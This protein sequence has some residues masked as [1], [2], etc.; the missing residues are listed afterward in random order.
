MGK[1]L[2]SKL[3]RDARQLRG[4]ASAIGLVVAAGVAALVSL[5]ST[6]HS[7]SGARDAYLA[8]YRFA[9]VFVRLA[10]T[11]ERIVGEV[12]DIPGV[13]DVQGRLVEDARLAGL[14][15]LATGR[16][17][18]LGG[19]GGAALNDLHLREGR[20]PQ[21]DLPGEAVVSEA[22]AKAHG[23]RPGATVKALV[24][25]RELQLRLSGIVLSPEYVYQIREG[26][27]APDDRRF[28][29]FW[30]PHRQL[31]RALGLEGAVNELSL[32]LVVR[33]DE[34]EVIERLDRLLA[35][36]GGLG[37]I[38]RD[39]QLSYRYLAEELRQL[40]SSGTSI[41]IVFLLV[42]S[43]LLNVVMSRLVKTQRMQIAMLK[44]FGYSNARIAAH[45]LSLALG[46][47]LVGVLVGV[48][49]GAWLGHELT[50]LYTRF[51]RLPDF[52][53]DLDVG[54]S[55]A[56]GG[57]AFLA[58]GL[59]SLG[60]IR[61]ATR[62]MPAEA[63]RPEAPPVYRPTRIERLGL[64]WLVSPAWRMIL[65]RMERRPWR[66]LSST[67][68][69]AAATAILV[70]GLFF[71][72]AIAHVVDFQLGVLQRHDLVLSFTSARS[73][74]ARHEVERLSGVTRAQG[75][76]AVP[77]ELGAG[78]RR[79][80]V[81]VLG[82][83]PADEL[84]R[85]VD[86]EGRWL[87]LPQ[88]GLILSS[89]LARQLELV[90]GDSVEVRVLERNGRRQRLTLAAVVR[91]VAGLSAYMRLDAAQRLMRKGNVY[92]GLFVVTDSTP[93]GEALLAALGRMPHLAAVSEVGTALRG[94][95]ET[96][97]RALLVM[98]LIMAAFAAVIA[99]GVIYNDGRVALAERQH[100]L[101]TLRVLGFTTGEIA[102]LFLGE[103][104]LVVVVALPVGLALGHGLARAIIAS[105][106]KDL[107][108]IPLVIELSTYVSAAL[109]IA[110]A[111]AIMAFP[112]A[113]QLARLDLVATLKARD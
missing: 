11:S 47:S 88:H 33:G 59:G 91:D 53:F 70:V 41:P 75:F 28:G 104:M 40:W 98:K 112:L 94:F 105:T 17:Q 96:F 87:A 86:I 54:V 99:V 22:F 15:V 84:R 73:T 71:D 110:G 39:D 32:T 10:P 51:F 92:S 79:R 77:V 46:V 69:I 42:A 109:I 2:S 72:D 108:V 78:G 38:S 63:M 37:A 67:L 24:R 45:Y 56:A 35:R 20:L 23:L 76:V 52:R 13:A 48:L 83:S 90:P 6:L 25:G 65:R 60:A 5:V 50:V 43:F 21:A 100:E 74:S 62:L 102:R 106:P 66:T 49:L 26:D 19:P 1:A 44:A 4:P 29:I 103:L 85:V 101:A 58:A 81:A 12:V 68:A 30:L 3:L 16:L 82:L 27:L 57:F 36:H 18:S 55:V 111:T 34:A 113:R 61:Q 64:V 95:Q 8:R 80:R 9:D 7:L 89:E 14:G 93:P 31:A 107:Y 97:G